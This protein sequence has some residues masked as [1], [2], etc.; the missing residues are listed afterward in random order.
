MQANRRSLFANW[1]ADSIAAVGSLDWGDN[2]S[3]IGWSEGRSGANL[4]LKTARLQTYLDAGS[5]RAKATMLPPAGRPDL[6]PPAEIT[7]N[8]RPWII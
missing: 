7:T 8:W 6:A 3:P 1:K 4:E 2:R 5:G